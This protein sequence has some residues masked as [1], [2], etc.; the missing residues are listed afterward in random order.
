[1][2]LKYRAESERGSP[3][4]APR[5]I[6]RHPLDAGRTEARRVLCSFGH[7]EVHSALLGRTE[8]RGHTTLQWTHRGVAHE[9]SATHGAH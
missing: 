7:I 5:Q 1:M 6:A 2:A 8:V 4:G 3:L 9:A